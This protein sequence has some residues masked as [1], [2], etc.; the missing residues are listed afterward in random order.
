MITGDNGILKRATEAKEKSERLEIIET[1]QIDIAGKQIQNDGSL[2]EEELVEILTSSEYNTKGTLSDNGEES[3]LDKILTSSDG[4]YQIPVSEIYNG[5]FTQNEN[6]GNVLE[7]LK[8]KISKESEDCMIDE[9]GNIIPINVWR[10]QITGED[11]CRIVGI[12]DDYDGRAAYN[13]S[14]T[15]DGKLEYEIPVYIKAGNKVYQVTELGG[16]ALYALGELK[17]IAIPNNV[18]SIGGDAFSYCNELAEIIIPNSVTSI[19][20]YAFYY[21]KSLIEI[22]IPNGVTSIGENTFYNCTG[23]TKITIP[24]SLTSIGY[25]AFCYCKSLTEITIPNGVTSI[26]ENAFNNCTGL[27]KITIP[28]SVTNLAFSVFFGWT[29][30]QII[31]INFKENELPSGWNTDGG[32]FS[33]KYGCNAQINYLED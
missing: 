32:S 17:S 8:T 30:S 18:T 10:Y 33:W 25:Q 9:D 20:S 27:T 19:G 5:P 23:L 7:A 29:S 11:T 13:G 26:G 21:C 2:S 16:A 3:V 14:I 6:P 4:Q 31:N 15:S 28:D 12:L 22:T 1:A 24:D